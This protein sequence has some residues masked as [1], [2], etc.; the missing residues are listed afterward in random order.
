MTIFKKVL[1]HFFLLI[2]VMIN[3]NSIA[4]ESNIEIGVSVD[5]RG[6]V[7]AQLPEKEVRVLGEASA[8]FQEDIITTGPNSYTV[9]E[10]DDDSR[11]SLRPNTVFSVEE[12]SQQPGEESARMHLYKGGLRA[13]SGQISKNNPEGAKLTTATA[14]VDIHAAEFDA[15]LCEEDCATENQQYKRVRAMAS[16]IVARVAH[17]KG[18]L[19]RTDA[20]NTKLRLI[21]GSPV[22]EG[23]ILETGVD[24]FAVI[25]FKDEGRVTLKEETR[26]K[27]SEYQYTAGQPEDSSAVL[28]LLKGGLR[29][30]TGLIARNNK[31]AYKFKTPTATIGIRGTG[32]DL[33]W[34]GSCETATPCGLVVF[35]W[36]GSIYV[37]NEFGLWELTVNQII[38]VREEDEPAKFQE[39]PPVF[40]VP[41]PD[42]IEIDFENLFGTEA[43]N[44]ITPGLYVAV[45]GGHIVMTRGN[46]S[47]DL[48]TGEGGSA[49]RDGLTLIRLEYVQPF[50][51]KDPY[52]VTIDLDMNTLFFMLDD[53]MIGQN[54]FECYVQ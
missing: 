42:E 3:T 44:E 36:D 48:G 45:Y 2:T 8:V 12:F 21:V 43:M 15:R 52:L 32:F 49:P 10:F 40:D 19:V 30:L 47:I 39:I 29:T 31:E 7:T 28:E 53:V 14:T 35:V 33:L 13:I 1:S 51:S 41:R 4:A 9:I 6:V 38:L 11:I 34:L 25:A 17:L 46:I 26:F 5:S 20:T 18:E 27:I 37:E 50:Q 54:E 16:A 23:D 22:F 24:S